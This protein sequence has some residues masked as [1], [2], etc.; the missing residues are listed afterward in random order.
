M[1]DNWLFPETTGNDGN[2]DV[3]S[4]HLQGRGLVNGGAMII[5]RLFLE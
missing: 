4:G 2:K 1:A 3:K 5:H